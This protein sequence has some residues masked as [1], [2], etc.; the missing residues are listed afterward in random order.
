MNSF[1]CAF[2]I[3]LEFGSVGFFLGEGKTGVRGEKPLGARERT[4]NKLNPLMASTPGV[5]PGPHWWE[6][7][8]LTTAPPL[9]PK[10]TTHDLLKQAIWPPSIKAMCNTNYLVKRVLDRSMMV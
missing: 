7:T 4:N 10:L 9:L 5:E 2:Q 3:A 8:A 6:A 1:K